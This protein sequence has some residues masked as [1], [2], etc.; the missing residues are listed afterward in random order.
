MPRDPRQACAFPIAA[1]LAAGTLLAG[2]ANDD[3]AVEEA[4]EEGPAATAAILGEPVTVVADVQEIVNEHAFTVGE[5]ETLVL[6]A[7]EPTVDQLEVGEEV[8]VSGTVRQLVTADFERDYD[9]FDFE[10]E[11]WV[12]DYE[13]DLVIVADNVRTTP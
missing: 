9:W 13:R 8:M 7:T 1:V 3:T 11:G 4:Q 6:S 5:D 10:Q 12:V 2:C